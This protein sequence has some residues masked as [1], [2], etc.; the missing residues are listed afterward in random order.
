MKHTYLYP[1]PGG[2]QFIWRAG[3]AFA[4]DLFGSPDGD[5]PG[6]WKLLVSLDDGIAGARDEVFR[7]IRDA[8]RV[9]IGQCYAIPGSINPDIA[10]IEDGVHLSTRE[11]TRLLW[12]A[13][14][15][16]PALRATVD[17]A[18]GPSGPHVPGRD[19]EPSIACFLDTHEGQRLIPVWM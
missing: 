1:L 8:E 16:D 9:C 12:D 4:T 14:V 13:P 6:T 2:A 15:M 11:V 17:R 7:L 5:D 3:R 18:L 19:P 10:D